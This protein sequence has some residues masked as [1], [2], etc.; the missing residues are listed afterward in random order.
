MVA[1]AVSPSSGWPTCS[2]R[3]SA[4]RSR[5]SSPSW[6][7]H[8]SAAGCLRYNV[9]AELPPTVGG[10]MLDGDE[11]FDML[12]GRRPAVE[13][14]V[15]RLA[16]ATPGLTVRRGVAVH[17]ILVDRDGVAVPRVSGVR[18]RRR[19]G[20][21]RRPRGRRG[22]APLTARRSARRRRGAPARTSS[23][24]TSATPTTPATSTAPTVACRRCVGR[25][26]RRSARS[27]SARSRPITAGGASSSSPVVGPARCARA[28]DVAVWRPDRR[29]VPDGPPLDRGRRGVRRRHRP[30]CRGPLARPGRRRPAGGHRRRQLGDAWACTSPTVGRGRHRSARCT[31]WHCATTSATC[32]RSGRRRCSGR[33]AHRGDRSAVVAGPHAGDVHVSARCEAEAAGEQYDTRR[34]GVAD[35]TGARRGGRTGPADAAPPCSRS[36]ACW[37]CG[38]DVLARPGVAAP[39][40]RSWRTRRSRCPVRRV[41]SSRTSSRGRGLSRSH[42]GAASPGHGV[43]G[44]ERVELAEEHRPRRLVVGRRWLR[45]SSGTKPAAGDQRGELAA[46]LERH[47]QVVAGVQDQRRAAGPAA[48]SL[49]DV[50]RREASRNRTALSGEVAAA[51]QLVELRPLLRRAVGQELRGEQLAERRVVAAPADAAPARRRAPPPALL[52]PWRARTSRPGRRRRRGSGG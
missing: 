11:R 3:G 10:G 38:V 34:P 51:L 16:A 35:G 44:E 50:D 13:G 28:R 26:R 20:A 2:C 42:D 31:R 40:P 12:T 46:L 9:L 18:T 22:G 15:A 5:R 32:G 48:A 14:V 8:S 33:R 43:L 39:G 27:T 45:L 29:A 21:V 47:A 7:R 24:T 19:R 4:R 36:R 30:R 17:G 52:R 37:R 6:P 23:S 1:S 25:S 49:G 41:R